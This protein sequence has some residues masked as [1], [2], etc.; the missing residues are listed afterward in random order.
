M[1]RRF[2]IIPQPLDMRSLWY[3]NF[4]PAADGVR[5]TLNLCQPT[6]LRAGIWREVVKNETLNRLFAKSNRS[7]LGKNVKK[8]I[9]RLR[10]AGCKFI[11]ACR[12]PPLSYMNIV[13]RHFFTIAP[14]EEKSAN[15][16]L[17]FY[18]L[19]RGLLRRIR[20]FRLMRAW[21]ISPA[22]LAV[23]LCHAVMRKPLL[24]YYCW[25]RIM[26]NIFW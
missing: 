14:A 9:R 6:S 11:V 4:P 19:R 21:V 18:Y 1:Q 12:T 17:D 8:W 7:A 25:S 3:E 5:R 16:K 26:L 22:S 10:S 13:P 15:D 2:P 23:S 24:L 20:C